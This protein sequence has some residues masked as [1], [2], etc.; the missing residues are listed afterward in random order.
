MLS[1]VQAFTFVETNYTNSDYIVIKLVIW[2][3]VVGLFTS[4]S[5]AYWKY[6]KLRSYTIN[7]ICK[8]DLSNNGVIRPNDGAQSSLVLRVLAHKNIINFKYNDTSGYWTF[9]C[10]Y[11]YDQM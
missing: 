11:Q 1:L 7:N 3:L 6:V 2:H 8:V 10:Y 9:L 4:D 5:L